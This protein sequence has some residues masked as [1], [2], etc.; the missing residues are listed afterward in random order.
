MKRVLI[1]AAGALEAE[2]LRRALVYMPDSE[3]IG[4]ADSSRAC[5]WSIR[6]W[7]PDLVV[8]N[9]ST[10]NE[11]VLER[12]AEIREGAPDATIVCRTSHGD[13]GW[14]R[15]VIDAGADATID[16][17]L[18][19]GRMVSLVREVTAGTIFRVPLPAPE[20]PPEAVA[21]L[22][23]RELEILQ[24]MAAGATNS[25]VASNLWV[26]EQTVKFHLSNVYRKLGVSNRTEASY[27]AHTHGLLKPAAPVPSGDG[28]RTTTGAAVAA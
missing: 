20:S 16:M 22:T 15:R 9:A 6:N 2:A 8:V 11:N 13:R 27:Y 24:M 17:A 12:I 1:V 10:D 25:M 23:A 18:D 14:L 5:N 3:V 21:N 19:L 4:F 7:A 26:T 28:Q